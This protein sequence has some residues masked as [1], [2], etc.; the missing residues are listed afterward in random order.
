MRGRV[1]APLTG[2]A[3]RWRGPGPACGN[4]PSVADL[5]LAVDIGGTKMAA[6]LVAPDGT[7]RRTGDAADA[8]LLEPGR[9]RGRC[10][11]ALARP[12]RRSRWRRGTGGPPRRLRHRVRGTDEPRR[13]GGVAPEHRRVAVLSP[14]SPTGGIDRAA[15]VRRQ[16]RQGAGARRGVGRRGGRLRR[17]HRHG[18]VDRGGRGHRGRRQTAQRAARQRGPHR[19]RRR[20]PRGSCLSVRQPGLPG[21]GGVGDGAGRRSPASRRGWR[22]PSGWRARARSSVAPWRR[23]PSC[24][25]CRWPW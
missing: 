20:R 16:R 13:R 15:H 24:S 11:A 19:P 12:G 18:R 10:G 1:P 14:A 2:A 3:P 25:T 9:R 23:W 8:G 22:R 7:L 6:G 21:G 5:A 4:N 17:L